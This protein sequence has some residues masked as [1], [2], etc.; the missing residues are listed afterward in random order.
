MPPNISFATLKNAMDEALRLYETIDGF[1]S[2][3]SARV[4]VWYGAKEP[5]M[6]TALQK[7]KRAWP[8]LEDHPFPGLGHGE[9]MAHPGLIAE[10]IRKF[11]ETE[12][13]Q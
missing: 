9:I 10:E 1:R 7:L 12:R 11:M 4:A 2:D 13:A 5:H 3:P 6:K 8:S